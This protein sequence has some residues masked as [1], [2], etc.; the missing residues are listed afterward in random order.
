MYSDGAK[1]RA[2]IQGNLTIAEGEPMGI[3]TSGLCG[4]MDIL[5]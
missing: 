5:M 2:G 4:T 3:W 1:D